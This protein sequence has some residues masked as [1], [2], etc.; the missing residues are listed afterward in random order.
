MANVIRTRQHKRRGFRPAQARLANHAHLRRAFDR[1]DDAVQLRGTRDVFVLN[2]PRREID[3]MKLPARSAESC[4][5]HVGV[6]EVTLRTFGA[7]GRA[8]RESP[9]FCL[10]SNV[11]NTGSESKRGRQHHTTSPVRETSAENWQ[12][13]IRPRFSSRMAQRVANRSLRLKCDAH[14]LGTP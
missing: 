3:Y 6:V 8:D 12:F 11:E 10:S 13:S 9:P 5:E 1:F 4:F 7:I 14:T 2:Q